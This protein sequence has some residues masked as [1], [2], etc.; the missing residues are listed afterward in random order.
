MDLW[1]EDIGYSDMKS[2]LTILKEQASILGSKTKNLVNAEV[3][4]ADIM[5]I[6]LQN[7]NVKHS[8]EDNTKYDFSYNFY[9]T[10]PALNNYRYRLFTIFFDIGL[11][12]VNFMLDGEIQKQICPLKKPTKANS[13]SEFMQILGH[14]F[15]SDR[16]RTI[17][18]SLISQ[19]GGFDNE[20]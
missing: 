10:A 3:R 8:V 4:I 15:N 16:T 19:S 1:P 5:D 20:K 12:P 7:L 2:P 17:I 18:S 6:K 11:Y 9:I 13:E 14:I